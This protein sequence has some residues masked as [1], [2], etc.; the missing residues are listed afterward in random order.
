MVEIGRSLVIHKHNLQGANSETGKI[1]LPVFF[2]GGDLKL[3][4]R[5]SFY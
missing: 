5:I 3:G 2:I 1:N 4:L